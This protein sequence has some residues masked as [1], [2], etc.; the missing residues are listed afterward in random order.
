MK[1]RK[2]FK[3]ATE[4]SKFVAKQFIMIGKRSI[5]SSGRFTVALSG[6][7]TPAALYDA[8]TS[9]EFR[10][11]I[12]WEKVFFFFGDERDVSP[13][14]DRSN[15]RMANENLLKP[16]EIPVTNIL[17]WQTEIIDAVGVAET[18]EKTL[19]RFFELSNGEFP[20]FDLILLGLGDDGH[21]A[22]LFPQTQALSETKRIAVSTYVEKLDTNRL[23]LTF[24]VLNKAKNIIFMVGGEEKAPALKEVLEGE[25]NPDK[26][27]AQ[28]VSPSKGKVLWVL[29]KAASELLKGKKGK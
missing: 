25:K 22:S 28:S 11:G 27:P 3:D 4:I 1:N 6:G 26:F 12:D 15:F 29:D 24:P 7:T 9:E 2:V 8:L 16:L 17:R 18:Y 19:R 20:V 14:S 13:M 5:K 21:T 23:T 10:D